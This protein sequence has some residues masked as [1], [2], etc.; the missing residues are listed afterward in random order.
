MIPF[1]RIAK[2]AYRSQIR[3]LQF[4]FV[5]SCCANCLIA[6]TPCQQPASSMSDI[7][8]HALL[9][10]MNENIHANDRL[11]ARYTFDWTS[12]FKIYS[13]KGKVLSDKSEKWVHVN[14]DGV[15]YARMVE[16]NGKPLSPKKQI[17]EQ[18]RSDSMGQ[19]GKGYDFVFQVI[20]MNP[21]DY[22]YSDFP[23]SYLDTLFDNRVIGRQVIDGRDTLVVES[24]P[25]ADAEPLSDREKTAM[26]WKETTW[27]DVEDAMPARYDAELLNT[28][29]YLLK[30]SVERL[31]FTR[32]PVT[33]ARNLKLPAY[34]WLMEAS[35]FHFFLWSKNYEV[36]RDDYY[37]Y[38]RF[39]SDAQILE[40]SMREIPSPSAS[41]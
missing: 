37:N 5:V 19:L 17:A 14:I 36:G 23:V 13:S 29:N 3:A 28:K 27:I 34:V 22:I 31:E 15:D 18:K 26:D 6:T 9:K 11:A 30:D 1:R 7:D 20:G 35:S 4:V 41:K 21:R 25:K 33:E 32:F 12:V 39:Q 2:M 10:R 40:D 24:T 8:L 16:V 38:R